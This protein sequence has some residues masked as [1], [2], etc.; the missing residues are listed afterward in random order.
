[1]NPLLVS[2][3]RRPCALISFGVLAACSSPPPVV[4]SQPASVPVTPLAPSP[5]PVVQ[6]P[7]SNAAHLDDYKREIA[8][9]ISSRSK[10]SVYVTQP[11][12]LLRGVVVLSIQMDSEG[13][14]RAVRT[15]RK[16][17]D[18]AELEKRAI[19]SVWRAAPFPR[20]SSRIVRG[21]DS[22]DFSETWLFNKDGRFQLRSIAL[23]QKTTNF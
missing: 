23:A 16:V 19:N 22:I 9:L 7:L 5:A 14:V 12:A 21:Q 6:V 18:D 4:T 15:L 11:Q 13:V 3:I 17:D 1:M 8:A 2:R 10:E 20:P